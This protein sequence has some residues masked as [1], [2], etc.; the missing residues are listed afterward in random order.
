[1]RVP[2]ITQQNV[3]FLLPA[4]IAQTVAMIARAENISIEKALMEFYRSQTYANLEREASKYWW[5]SPAQLFQDYQW[6]K[7]DEIASGGAK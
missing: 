7:E 2:K 3:R 6:D 5:F 4:K 1:M